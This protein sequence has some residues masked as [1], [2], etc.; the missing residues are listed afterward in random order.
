[1]NLFSKKLFNVVRL[2][3]M[4]KYRPTKRSGRS[5]SNAKNNNLSLFTKYTIFK[6]DLFYVDLPI[7]T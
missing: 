2:L 4:Y 1:M 6:A 5:N 3:Y 7:R